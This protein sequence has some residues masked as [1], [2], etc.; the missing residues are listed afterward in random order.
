MK[1]FRILN[2]IRN[3]VRLKKINKMKSKINKKVE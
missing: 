2:E 3:L 1:T